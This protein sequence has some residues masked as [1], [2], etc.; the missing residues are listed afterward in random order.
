[1]FA[2]HWV[3]FFEFKLFGLR[4]WVFLLH[5]EMPRIG[6]AHQ[7]YLDCCG[8]RHCLVLSSGLFADLSLRAALSCRRRAGYTIM[9]LVG[10][11]AK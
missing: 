6:G 11:R 7:F 8:F 4:P 10:L 3:V 5:V 9:I 1:M 2:N